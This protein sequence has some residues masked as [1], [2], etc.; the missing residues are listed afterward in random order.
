MSDKYAAL[1]AA[2]EKAQL[3]SKDEWGYDTDA[4]HDEANPAT[5]LELLAERDA[6][7]ARIAEL[8]ARVA[9]PAA[10]DVLA[11]RQR[12]V[13]VEGWTSSH[14]DLHDNNEMAFAASCY[15]F[16]AASASWDLEDD[17][18]PYDWHRVPKQ[19][20][21]DPEWWKP[22]SP[23]RDLVKAGALILAE[24]ERIDRADGISLKIE[25]E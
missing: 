6:D 22:K 11:E 18:F 16:H 15:A 5:I 8:E 14:D 23:R 9:S 2:A 17:D 12:Q 21:W 20:P 4:F 3:E 19:W 7:R 24:I 13:N 10:T 25:G 1:R